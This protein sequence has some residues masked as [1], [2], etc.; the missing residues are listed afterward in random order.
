MSARL[1]PAHHQGA[2]IL[3]DN[4]A[5]SGGHGGLSGIHAMKKKVMSPAGDDMIIRQKQ[6]EKS[7]IVSFRGK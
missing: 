3:M 7:G 2:I 6:K 4:P 1:P 5:W